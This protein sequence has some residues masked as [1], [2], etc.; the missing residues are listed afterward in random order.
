MFFSVLVLFVTHTS[1]AQTKIYGRVVN[2]TGSP[3]PGASVLLLKAIDSSLVKGMISNATGIYGFENATAGNYK[4]AAS[5]TGYKVQYSASFVVAGQNEIA[6]DALKLSDEE[7]QLAEVTV[8]AK[9]PLFEQKMDR[10][11]VNV[12]SS[13]TAAGSTALEVLERSPG[14]IIDRQN[15]SLSMNGKNGV[16]VMINGKINRM[17]LSAVVQM[18]ANMTADNIEKIELI[19]TPPA[20]FDAEGNAGY[21]NIVLKQNTQFGTNGSYTL[22]GGYG[23]GEITEA[24]I[25]F[26]HRKG[27]YNL[28]GD[29][30]FSRAR[31]WQLFEFYN[32]ILYGGKISEKYSAADRDFVNLN[33]NGRI[34][35]DYELSKKTIAGL[36]FSSY[37]DRVEIESTN[38]SSLLVNRILDT[39]LRI[40]NNELNNWRNYSGNANLQHTFSENQKLTVNLDYIYYKD[41]NPVNYLNSYYDG[42]GN[43]IYDQKV[44]STKE[45]PIQF[46][47]GAA[48][49]TR[50]LSKKVQL[51]SGLK[52]TQSKFKNNVAINRMIQSGWQKDGSLSANYDLKETINAAY[53]AMSITFNEKLSMKL[54]LRYEYTTSNLGSETVKNIVDRKYGNFFPSFFI[55]RTFTEHTSGNFSYSRRITRPTFNNMA[56]FVIF[57]DPYTFFSGNPGLQP[58]ISNSASATYTIKKNI[59]SLAY[60]HEKNPITNFSPSIDAASNTQTLAAENQKDQKSATINFS[61]PITVTKWWSMQNNLLG[62]WTELNAKFKGDAVQLRQKYY[63]FSTTQSFTLPKEYSAEVSGNYF[64]G[65]LFGVYQIE[66]MGILNAGIQKKLVK[67]KSTIRFNVSN[68]L[69]TII[70]RPSVNLPDQNLIV[71]ARLIFANPSFK[72]TYTHNF[73]ND[74]LKEKRNRSTGAEAEKSRVQ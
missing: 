7:V 65:G 40:K 45:T 42:L 9:R 67:Q 47:V 27:K 34:G 51:E 6:I 55:S 37:D 30:S 56:P 10:M 36:L 21:I 61:I 49:Y 8:S 50:K 74:K 32:K 39:A 71:S 17:P 18:L 43:F 52:T 19:T 14:I 33:N 53:S 72:L 66:P 28:Y 60:S 4:I 13:I 48:D 3:V 5:F 25:N 23:K 29:Y 70:A 24:S 46:W 2:I 31:S 11:I 35:V 44:K 16:V 1:I 12:A 58:S 59:I 64:S 22:T 15:N 38:N 62:A 54:G 69:N 41:N 26:N 73:G 57:V 20:N 63:N 68:I